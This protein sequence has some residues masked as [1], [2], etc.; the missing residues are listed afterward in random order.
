VGVRVPL[1]TGGRIAAQTARAR[2]ELD[3][4]RQERR[5]LE[6]Q[7]G[8]EVQTAQAELESARSEVEVA[9]Q[10]EGLA[11]EALEQARH[12]FQAGVS[13]NIEVIQAQDELARAADNRIDAL[14][15]LNQSRA[16]LARAMGQLET[17]YV[18]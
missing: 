2:E 16:D 1:F 4:I 12:R 11:R 15:R 3:R 8:M 18:R 9:T 14:Y 10:A 17:S 7:V 13:N 5:D 6:A